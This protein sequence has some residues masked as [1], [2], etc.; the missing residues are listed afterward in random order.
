MK[1]GLFDS[2]LVKGHLKIS[3]ETASVDFRLFY[4]TCWDSQTEDPPTWSATT[5]RPVPSPA[6]VSCKN[7]KQ[8]KQNRVVG[9]S[10]IWSSSERS[11]WDGKQRCHLLKVLKVS[12]WLL[13]VHKVGHI[14]VFRITVRQDKW[15]VFSTE[16][17]FPKYLGHVVLKMGCI[18][19]IQHVWATTESGPHSTYLT[20]LGYFFINY[21][22]NLVH[23]E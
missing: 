17:E 2:C 12:W 16:N 14:L 22:T 23:R 19:L 13:I 10:L 5:F 8:K 21:Q 11:L 9:S 7:K 6:S 18:A 20:D 4:D 3:P 15:V 1:L